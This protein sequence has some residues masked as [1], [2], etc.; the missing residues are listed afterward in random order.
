MN[1]KAQF[2]D[3]WLEYVAGALLVLAFYVAAR[4]A[5]MGVVYVVA[6]I[7]GAMLGKFWYSII[8]KKKTTIY[9]AILTMAV[10][11]GMILGSVGVDRRYV[12]IIFALGLVV[13]YAAHAEKWIRTA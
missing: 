11:L 9:I 1:K 3:F 8:K 4:G 6:L 10:L 13:S 2:A 5:Y 7:L 12:I